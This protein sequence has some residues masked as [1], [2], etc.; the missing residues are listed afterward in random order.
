MNTVANRT[1]VTKTWGMSFSKM[2][3]R[4]KMI[5]PKLT[6]QNPIFFRN[7]TVPAFSFIRANKREKV[8]RDRGK[9]NPRKNVSSW[10]LGML[11]IRK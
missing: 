4:K 6:N 1:E 7:S 5:T 8:I 9:E 3:N 11:T 2:M 10:S